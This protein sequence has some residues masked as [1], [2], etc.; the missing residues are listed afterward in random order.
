MDLV[1]RTL[2]AASSSRARAFLLG[3]SA[4]A[5]GATPAQ[6]QV[7]P[8]EEGDV[9]VVSG[10]VL[11]NQA[12]IQTRR[13]STAIVDSLARD[14]I[15]ALPDITIAESLRRITGVTT[16]YND[17]I[18]QFA[19]IR[20][21][22]PDFVPVTLNGM[23]LATTG[24][25]GEGT[26]R[27]NLQVIP[28]DAVQQL[29][30]YKTLSPNLDAGALA[31][32]IDIR[33]ISA[34]DPGRSLLSVTGSGSYSSYMEVDDSNS[35]GHDKDSPIG[36]G[37]NA[38]VGPRFGADESWG[39]AVTA[40]YEMRPRTQSNSAI[41][42]RLYY[43]ATGAPTTP[44]AADWNGIGVPESF[45]S[46]NY[47]NRFTKYGA[48]ARLDYRPNDR[49]QSS[50]FGFAYFSEEEET[51]NTNR[52]YRLDQPR[53]TTETTGTLRA[54][55]AD[56]Q[57]RYNT[58]ERDQ[59]GLQWLN[60]LEIGDR[61]RLSLDLSYTNAWFRSDRPF[62]TFVYNAGSRLSYDLT[63]LDA[64]FTYDNPGAF[65]DPANYSSTT[66]YRDSRE[67]KEDV[68]EARL[69]YSFNTG[70]DDRGIGFAA[71]AN[72][73]TLD[74]TRDNTGVNYVT[75]AANL[76]GLAFIPDFASPGYGS[77]ALWLDADTFWNERVPTLGVN[78]AATR[79]TS[80]QNDYGYSEEV[81]AGYV[82]A[83]YSSDSFRVDL[84]ARLDHV[85]FTASMAQILNGALQDGLID[86]TGNDTHL[87]PYATINYSIAP[88]LRLK[89]AAT[90]ALGRPN[91]ETVATV[92]DVDV[93]DLTISRGNPD[94]QPRKSTNLDL[95]LEYFFSG[96]RGMVTLT[97]FYKKIR[98]DIV[99]VS[100]Q[101]VIDGLNY[102]V[103]QP[104]NGDDTELKGVEFGV[105][106]NSFGNVA[107]WLEGFG[108]AANL[109][110][111]DGRTSYYSNGVFQTRDELQFQSKI[112]ANAAVFYSLADGSELRLAMSHQGQYLES[113]AAA[114]W[115]DIYI[116]PFT[117]F[118]LTA[119]WAVTPN[120]QLRLEGRNIFNAD[121]QRNTGPNQE[122]YRAGLEVGNTW[123]V[124][125]NFR[126]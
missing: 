67:A 87:L 105:I 85:D 108:A 76:G 69:D 4:F 28:G 16:V 47:T 121:R 124:R 25:L 63:N 112:A 7:A 53:N 46:H 41:V 61:G 51:R 38:V 70:V 78:A 90:Q 58:F 91:P 32:L 102:I 29:L 111:V 37:V 122:H 14:E 64:P 20:G 2:A 96:G 94:I 107:N 75:N 71:G 33:T 95:G 39:L 98:D 117:T 79:T 24:D 123:Y 65:V 8:E 30:V 17:D 10:S 56:I 15:G 3:A 113:Y 73:R 54:R 43:T 100:T 13:E 83:N 86:K 18:G 55:S 109:I 120:I 36:Y 45:V 11:Q 126:L 88:T 35:W 97:G 34:F 72:W 118:D 19:S 82:N 5:L 104:V 26:R 9:I 52:A 110:W 40:Y 49:F 59:S 114:V 23:I 115:N 21:S 89:A 81:A 74:L 6:A 31:G 42:E 12:E 116:Q 68:Y 57:W 106:N 80:L 60:D 84:G 1:Y 50:L 103:T 48:T 27:V 99:T 101:E 93:T 119:R 92:E 77:E 62:V 44:Q 125:A 22:H 66:L